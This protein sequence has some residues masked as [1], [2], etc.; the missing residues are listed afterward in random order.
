SLTPAVLSVTP[1]ARSM[2][3]VAWFLFR[4]SERA[5]TGS[6]DRAGDRKQT[7]AR[8]IN[9]G[10]DSHNGHSCLG[11]FDNLLRLSYSRVPKIP[12]GR[13]L[14]KRRN[15]VL[16]VSRGRLSAA[17]RD[18]LCGDARSQPRAFHTPLCFLFDHLLLW[19][20]LKAENTWQVIEVVVN[21][22]LARVVFDLKVCSRSPKLV[23]QST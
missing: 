8:R 4:G 7:P 14:C 21:L 15:S 11:R 5:F 22:A 2:N 23:R 16:L 20:H 18:Q 6:D 13:V 9:R 1:M 19:F 3:V 17:L 12:G 10:C